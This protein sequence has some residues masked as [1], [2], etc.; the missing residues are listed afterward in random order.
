[1]SAIRI[2]FTAAVG[3]LI[4]GVAAAQDVA[5]SLGVGIV[6]PALVGGE[7][8][9]FYG[10]PDLDRLPDE[11]A[12]S[13]SL[14]FVDGGDHV[15][16]AYAPPWFVP[17]LLKLDYDMLV[18]RAQALTR[19][20]VQVVVDRASGET[21]WVDRSAVSFSGWPEFLLDVVAVESL[22]PTTNPVRSSPDTTAAALSV[23]RTTV[24]PLAVRGSWLQV[25]VEDDAVRTRSVGWI[26]W[27]DGDTLLVAWSPLS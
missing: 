17:E 13:D 26:R 21:R 12:P 5:S 4:F 23:G 11:V 18:M 14:V 24:R 27:R 20:W 15:D 16:I 10:A 22:D 6:R 7:V 3:M 8:L 19:Q 25:A 1:M 9:Y 2:G